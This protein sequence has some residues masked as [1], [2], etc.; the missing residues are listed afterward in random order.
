MMT[1]ESKSAVIAA[2]AVAI[3]TTLASAAEGDSVAELIAKI[4]DKDDKVRGPAWQS[5]GKFGAPAVKPLAEVMTDSEMEVARSAKRALWLIV[6][7]AGRPG[8]NAERKAVV[9]QLV[10]LLGNG[11]PVVRREVLWMLS[12]IAGDEAVAPIAK[13]LADADLREDARCALQR[14]PGNQAIAAL[15]QGL[16]EAPEAFK[17]NLADS[18][19]A[20]GVKVQGYPS[21]KLVPV[22]QTSVKV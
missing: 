3:T 12:E 5:A 1:N 16:A 18:L 2:S 20:R 21:Q 7:N 4:K 19:R 9:E 6:R 10:P 13:L 17:Y 22:K 15:K 8:A 11:G 14:I